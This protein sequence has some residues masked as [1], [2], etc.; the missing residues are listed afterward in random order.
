MTARTVAM[1]CENA[2]MRAK[3]HRTDVAKALDISS[4][5]VDKL[6]QGDAMPTLPVVMTIARL[7]GSHGLVMLGEVMRAFEVEATATAV[8]REG[9]ATPVALAV[10]HVAVEV[11]ELAMESAKA[12]ADGVIDAHERQRLLK[13]RDDVIRAASAVQPRQS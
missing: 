1:S 3:V 10:A 7:C 13:E 9:D 12:S 11:G 2:L 4:Q 5:R 8:Q 6:L